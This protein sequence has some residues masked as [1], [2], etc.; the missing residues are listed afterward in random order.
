MVSDWYTVTF[1][2]L[3]DLWKGFIVF[4][5][6]L[7]GAL[8][9]FLI[10]WFVAIGVGKLVVG[11][12]KRL[13]FN[14]IFEKGTWKEAL[15]RAE[16]KIDAAGFIGAVCKWILVIVFLM[17]AVGILGLKDFADVLKS[18]LGYLPNVVVAALIFVVA[19]II[20]DIVEK[21]VRAAVE[22]TKMGYG[23]IAGVIVRWSIWIFAILAVLMQL[24]IATEL[25]LTLFTGFVALA[26]IAGGI[27]FGLGGKETAAEILEGLKKKLKG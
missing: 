25:I 19:M 7:I 14:Q 13:K 8:I 24:K 3:V 18:V 10:G 20:A 27:A 16:L 9:V 12:L 22:G 5:P 17:A 4:L 6:K 26:A 11:I 23:H 1:Q 15:E 2:A 21:V